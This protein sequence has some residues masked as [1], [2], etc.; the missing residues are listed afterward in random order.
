MPKVL[1]V[2]SKTF[3]TFVGSK[4]VTPIILINRR[5]NI[6]FAIIGDVNSS[7]IVL[8]LRYPDYSIFPL[9]LWLLSD[10][11]LLF[12]ARWPSETNKKITCLPNYRIFKDKKGIKKG[13][14]LFFNLKHTHTHTF[15]LHT[16]NTYTNKHTHSHPTYI[17]RDIKRL[18]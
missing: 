11:K 9:F 18:P 16:S 10:A 17:K 6:V 2:D 14:A 15:I 1:F 7:S 3:G 5:G 12:T 4:T 13:T 8:S